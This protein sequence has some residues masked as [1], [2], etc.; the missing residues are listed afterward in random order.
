MDWLRFMAT[1]LKQIIQ[2]LYYY[3]FFFRGSLSESKHEASEE[4]QIGETEP[5]SFSLDL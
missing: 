3:Y 4:P 5:G 2:S 1:L